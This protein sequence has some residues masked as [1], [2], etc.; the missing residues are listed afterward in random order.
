MLIKEAAAVYAVDRDGAYPVNDDEL[1]SYIE[2]GVEA[3]TCP[4]GDATYEIEPYSKLNPPTESRPTWSY[5][6]PNGD[7]DTNGDQE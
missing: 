5:Q 3:L 7:H 6:Y 4:S 1:N 2:G